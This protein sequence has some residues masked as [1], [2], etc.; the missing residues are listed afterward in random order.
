[1]IA[2]NP[3]THEGQ[4]YDRLL[5]NLAV[6]TTVDDD[7]SVAMRIVPARVDENDTTIMLHSAAVGV[8]I[9]RAA[10]AQNAAE[11]QFIQNIMQAISQLLAVRGA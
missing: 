7:A 10:E 3:V 4:V 6:S 9:G 2:A 11:Q 1:M 5:V 8:V